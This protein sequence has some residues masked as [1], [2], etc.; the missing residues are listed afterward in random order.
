MELCVGMYCFISN[1]LDCTL[2]FISKDLLATLFFRPCFHR[3]FVLPQ[4]CLDG[5]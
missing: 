2:F 4:A 1:L 3:A 5:T